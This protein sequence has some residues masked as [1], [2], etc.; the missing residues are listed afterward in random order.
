MYIVGM[1]RVGLVL[2]VLTCAFIGGA[3]AGG[4]RSAASG[5]AAASAAKPCRAPARVAPRLLPV[6][7]RDGFSDPKP[8]MPFRL[9]RAG[10]IGAILWADPLRSPPPK[11]HTTKILWV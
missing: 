6:W 1:V 5:S 9:G 4:A 8:R 11:D 3:P 7:A 2:V 10:K